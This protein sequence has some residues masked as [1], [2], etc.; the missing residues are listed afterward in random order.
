VQTFSA[1][2]LQHEEFARAVEDFLARESA[3]VE[4]Y[5]DELGE[6]APF[7]KDDRA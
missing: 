4:R 5:L 2:W 7:R 6:R 3:G 1:H